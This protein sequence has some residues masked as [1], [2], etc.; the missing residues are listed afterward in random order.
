MGLMW[1][2]ATMKLKER[3]RLIGDYSPGQFLEFS[4]K[5]FRRKSSPQIGFTSL[6]LTIMFEHKGSYHISRRVRDAIYTSHTGQ[7]S[8]LPTEYLT[9][10]P[11]R[12][13]MTF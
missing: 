1:P 7:L 5:P 9:S 4:G 3:M 12:L 2:R 13:P 8:R 10:M 11:L 6:R